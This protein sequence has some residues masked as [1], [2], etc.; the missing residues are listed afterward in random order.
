[1]TSDRLREL[2]KPIVNGLFGDQKPYHMR[3]GQEEPPVVRPIGMILED[4]CSFSDGEWAKYAFSRE[5]LNGRF[6]DEQRI[7]L[8]DHAAACG[9]EYAKR[10]TEKYGTSDVKDLAA[11][12]GL[13][14]QFPMMPQNTERVLF[15]EFRE[16]NKV[17]I[18]MD[19]VEKGTALLENSNA[20][21][22]LG[23]DLDIA[24]LLLAHEEFHYIEEQYKDEIWTKTYK[25]QLWKLGPIRN[26]SSVFVLSEI[27]AMAF[28][29]ALNH[30]SW[31]PYMMDAFLTYGYSPEAA[32]AL[33]EDMMKIVGREPRLPEQE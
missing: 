13:N 5:P 18:Y 24:T 7:E 6:T 32:S 2:M 26:N 23:S 22:F 19:G 14:V 15:A 28:A 17:F 4:L 16:P 8:A 11:H 31:S 20:A 1:M 33:Y 29:Q 30:I 21:Q 25:I 10:M 9:R 27:A 3:R 12:L